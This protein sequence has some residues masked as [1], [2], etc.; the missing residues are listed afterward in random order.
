MAVETAVG[1]EAVAIGSDHLDER[2]GFLSRLEP[3]GGLEHGELEHI[4][5]SI[6]VRI[7]A[8]GKAVQVESGRPGRC[9]YVV[10]TAPSSSPTK[11]RPSRSLGR[12][13]LRSSTPLTGLPPEFTTRARTRSTLWCIPKEIAT[14]LL[15]RPEG[16][17]FVAASL[18]ERLLQAAR[19]MRGVPDVR[20]RSVATLVRSAPLFCDP[21]TTIR[22]AAR[23][24]G[25]ERASALLVHTAAGLG[26]VTDFDLRQKV[27]AGDVSKEAPLSAVMTLPVQTVAA[28]ELAPEA[29]VQMMAAGVNHLPVLDRAGEAIGILAAKNLMSLDA[30]SPFALSRRIQRAR[31]EDELARA[32]ADLPSLF[33]DL[34]MP[35]SLHPP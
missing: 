11:E 27:I 12:G 20:M 17:K 18:R 5:S 4:A 31:D 22:E 21:Q 10:A 1:I 8:A 33:V 15:S 25:A 34:L 19:T 35:A 2:V 30:R 23:L 6:T 26:I 7:A 13:G 28:E 9:L 24:M 3:F 16:V 14:E 32:A 29:A